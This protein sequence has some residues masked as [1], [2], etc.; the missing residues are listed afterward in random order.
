VSLP[1]I[2]VVSAM[3]HA[4]WMAGRRA[5]GV[6]SCKAGT[7]EELM[8]PYEE[9]S[10]EAKHAARDLVATVYSAIDMASEPKSVGETLD[11]EQILDLLRKMPD[12]LKATMDFCAGDMAPITRI[13]LKNT[14]RYGNKIRL[15]CGLEFVDDDD[16][17]L[18]K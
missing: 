2:D 3:A 7:G 10:D 16:D 11:D 15:V 17:E 18:R 6:L 12:A 14:D 9:L 8:V 13:T 5:D 4:V 1:N